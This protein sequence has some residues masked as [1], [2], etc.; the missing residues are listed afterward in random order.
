MGIIDVNYKSFCPICGYCELTLIKTIDICPVCNNKMKKTNFL[1]RRK[2]DDFNQEQ[3]YDY[4][5]KEII[6]T[7]FDSKMVELRKKY[8][9]RK[10]AEYQQQE[11][12]RNKKHDEKITAYENKYLSFVEEAQSQGILRS[13]AEDIASYAMQHNMYS[14]PHCPNC[15]SVD[16][17]KI[18]AGTKIVKTAAFGVIGAI[19][20]SGKTWKCNKCN[21]KW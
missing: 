10:Y 12:E 5:Q 9:Q 1:Q 2:F 19:S 7:N 20:D 6:K 11:Q 14:L 16:V 17:S 8:E 13:R 15:G 18:S 3:L 4:I 21:C